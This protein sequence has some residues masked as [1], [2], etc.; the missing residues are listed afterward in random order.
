M[1][2]P[3]II[4]PNGAYISD[5]QSLI[6]LA[7][8]IIYTGESVTDLREAVDGYFKAVEEAMSRKIE[9]VRA[10]L[11]R[12]EAALQQAEAALS[13][14]EASGYYD[15]DGDYHE[16]NCSCERSEVREAQREV[17]RIEKKLKKMESVQSE[18]KSELDKYRQPFGF[19]SPGGGDGILKWLGESHSKDSNDRMQTILNAVE[20]YIR[21]SARRNGTSSFTSSGNMPQSSCFESDTDREKRNKFRQATERVLERQREADNG[22]RS[23]RQ[24]NA[25][26]LCSGCNRPIIACT[27]PNGPRERERLFNYDFSR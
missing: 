5:H 19:T 2:C 21:T 14:C 4:K 7:N 1:D 11:S 20:E 18:L 17:D 13:S 10:E 12:A 3:E 27:C 23:V 26:A 24:A 6:D 22:N 15:D 25:V 8:T 16:P 9:E